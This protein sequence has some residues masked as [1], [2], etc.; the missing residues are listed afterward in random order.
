MA[1]FP[2]ST[3]PENSEFGVDTT[4]QFGQTGFDLN[5][6][7]LGPTPAA[8]VPSPTSSNPG[9]SSGG[10]T[11]SSGGPS[12]SIVDNF[13][14]KA[15]LL[16]PALTSNYI[17]KF[18]PPEAVQSFLA[19]REGTFPGSNYLIRQ[20]QDLIELSCTEASLP[21]SSLM[22]NEINDDYTGVTERHAYRR[23]FDDRMDFTFYVDNDYRIINFFEGWISY[24]GKE[25]LQSDLVNRNYFYRF[26]FPDEYQTDD[27]YVTKFE[28]D[29]K[30][31]MEYRFIRAYP[32]SITSM[33]VSYDASQL[34]K[35]TVSFTY[36]RY[37]R[38]TVGSNAQSEPGPSP[39]PG[40][41]SIGN[42]NASPN[43]PQVP[44]FE[45]PQFG[46]PAS[47][48]PDFAGPPLAPQ[49]TAPG[50][51]STILGQPTGSGIFRTTST[52]GLRSGSNSTGTQDLPRVANSPTPSQPTINKNAGNGAITNFNPTEEGTLQLSLF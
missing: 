47:G 14:V 11:S 1:R 4:G 3:F 51:P 50:V 37:V 44:G 40:I 20:N 35:C 31:A 49:S 38:R 9:T 46:G 8:G 32:I 27:L 22:T 18:S 25:D 2:I 19:A 30:S 52:S 28:R 21:G 42:P 48:I 41:P 5:Q 17:C 26:N 36:I 13:K 33:P 7:P 34:L 43:F 12:V 24:C 45:N 16:N 6:N 23:Q 29:F 15:T 39:I 10:S